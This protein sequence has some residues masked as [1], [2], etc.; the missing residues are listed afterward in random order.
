MLIGARMTQG[1]LL[2]IIT[3][4]IANGGHEIFSPSMGVGLC[5]NN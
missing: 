2:Q 1:E 5:K 3:Q 4:F